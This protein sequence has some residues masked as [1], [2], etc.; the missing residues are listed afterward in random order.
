[1]RALF[2]ITLCSILSFPL[3]AQTTISG[4]VTNASGG[5]L[6]AATVLL[7][8]TDWGTFTDQDGVFKLEGIAAGKYTIQVSFIGNETM[9]RRVNIGPDLTSNFD[10]QMRSTAFQ[11]EELVVKA[12]RAGDQTPVTYSNLD[13]EEIEQNNL[14]QDV[15]YLLKWTPSAVVTSDAGTGIGYTGIRIRGTDPTRTNVTINGIPL[16]DSESQGVFWVDLPDFV[17]STENIQ[18]QRG[19]GTSTFGTGAFG[20][21]INLSTSKL[22]QEAYGRIGGTVGS[23]NTFKRNLQFGSGLLSNKFIIEGR[24]SKITSDGYIDRASADLEGY[25]LSATYLGEKNSLKFTT[26]S[27][28]EVTYQAWYGIG[29]ELLD[30]PQT[31][32]FNPAGTE[33]EGTPHEN[34]VDDYLQTHYQLHYTQ[35][36]STNW[37]G[38]AALHYTKGAGFFEEYVAD[39]V[40]T[41]YGF[42]N[43]VIGT[44]ETDISDLIR[45]RWLDN[46]FYGTIL[47]ANYQDDNN[48]FDL[49][50]SGGYNIYEGRHF[51][52]V[53]WAQFFPDTDLLDGTYYDEDATKKDI[54]I[55]GKLNYGLTPKLNAYVDLQ[56]RGVNYDL[57][58]FDGNGGRTPQSES[59][60]FFNPKAGLFYQ[61]NSTSKAYASFGIA[62]REPNRNDYHGASVNNP[63][64]PERLYNTEVGAERNWEK[65]GISANFYY[66]SYRDQLALNGDINQDGE[67][68]RINIDNSYRAGIELGGLYRPI[69]AFQVNVNATIS[70]NKIK[71]FTEE[72][73]NYAEDF[74]EI[75]PVRILREDTDLAFSPNL[76]A[77][78]QI[79]YDFLTKK[80]G[81]SLEL[82]LL[83]KYVGQQFLDNSSD[84]NNVLDAYFYSDL[85]LT[86]QVDDWFGQS[87][88]VI[89]LVRNVFDELYE[90]NGWSYRYAMG[91]QTFLDRGYYP[92]AGRNF[93]LGVELSF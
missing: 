80:R 15:P 42:G 73:D 62:N 60:N 68:T 81:S 61:I 55:F 90:T 93:L 22:N 39:Q 65:G 32:T 24:L 12:I 59:L 64:N 36:F 28:H 23:F 30:D 5:P 40:L 21:T 11:I 53:V 37:S 52:E 3:G 78:T 50:L 8:D 41:N 6:V 7:L 16:N 49:T 43:A 18:I 67:F 17:T 19:V 86:F 57:L 33:K 76:I 14:G 72:L 82:S 20:A 75:E 87:V 38:T 54:T 58:G 35:Q 79:S 45:R 85:R 31:R 26:F 66:M 70:R 25:F 56:F 1:M 69:Q 91:G 4:R 83:S 9:E 84:E 63:P 92:Q 48:K 2:S 47:S 44:E 13:K 77:S 27:G 51:G 10:F 46:D 88:R 34:Q 29:P 74:S 71:A 89:A